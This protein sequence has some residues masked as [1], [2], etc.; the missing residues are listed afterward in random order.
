MNRDKNPITRRQASGPR[1]Q[2]KPRGRTSN[3]PPS[4]ARPSGGARAQPVKKS[5]QHSKSKNTLGPC[6]ART[7]FGGGASR[8]V[9]AGRVA[10]NPKNRSRSRSQS[11]SGSPRRRSQP[12]TRRPRSPCSR[13]P[14]RYKPLAVDDDK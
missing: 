1:S 11:R 2:I 8:R 6:P 4:V 3:N 7:A 14:I 13:R 9:G 5:P 12:Q 10:A